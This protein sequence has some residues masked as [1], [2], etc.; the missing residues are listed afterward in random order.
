V[1][2]EQLREGFQ[3][4]A[5]VSYE[6]ARVEAVTESNAD[7][8]S[9][10]KAFP[11]PDR[12]A[13]QDKPQTKKKKPVHVVVAAPV[14]SGG[15]RPDINARMLLRRRV[16]LMEKVKTAQTVGIL[17][18]TLGVAGYLDTVNYLKNLIKSS[19]RKPYLFSVGKIN[20]PKI[21]NFTAIDIFVLVAC[22]FSVLHD[23]RDYHI[24]IVAPF[25]LEV[26]LNSNR[27]WDGAFSMQFAD[28]LPGG[29]LH[30]DYAD[31]D[32]GDGNDDDDGDGVLYS[33]V[34]RRLVHV[35]DY[36]DKGGEGKASPAQAER[37]GS[38][39]EGVL[40]SLG[41]TTLTKSN[42]QPVSAVHERFQQRAFQGLVLNQHEQGADEVAKVQVEQGLSGI[43]RSYKTVGEGEEGKKNG[44]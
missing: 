29:Q 18:G 8:K 17:C 13:D 35:K 5:V 19:G 2:P 24:D 10:F 32:D 25:E 14:V 15:E 39:A 9:W 44:L 41:S 43:A 28:I 37:E 34:S 23:S 12:P 1:A 40:I 31:Q 42:R 22:P 7:E 4:V 21:C 38:A 3:E 6:D 30:V 27:E 36:S 20:E 16:Y 26:A 33:T 11:V